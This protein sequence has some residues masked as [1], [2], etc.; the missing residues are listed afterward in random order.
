MIWFTLKHS[1]K[2]NSLEQKNTFHNLAVVFEQLLYMLLFT[3]IS[4]FSHKRIFPKI[5]QVTIPTLY[6]F[7]KYK[8]IWILSYVSRKYLLYYA[9]RFDEKVSK[10]FSVQTF[11]FWNQTSYN[12]FPLR[13]FT[14]V[15]CFLPMLYFCWW[16]NAVVTRCLSWS[17]CMCCFPN[18]TGSTFCEASFV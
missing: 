8:Y 1:T 7:G 16:K 3:F 10:V 15:Y 6:L 4:C 14:V 5:W 2:K 17:V 18:S 9:T 13:Q 11:V 12:A